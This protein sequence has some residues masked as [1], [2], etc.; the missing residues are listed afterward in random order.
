VW[1][2]RCAECGEDMQ[3]RFVAEELI[4]WWCLGCSHTETPD[5]ALDRATAM[6]A[7]EHV[8]GCEA[9]EE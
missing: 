9:C 3:P 6:F 7:S 2:M 8:V 4:M 1:S 5:Q